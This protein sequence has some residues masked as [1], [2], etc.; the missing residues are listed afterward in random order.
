MS[1]HKGF[2]GAGGSSGTNARP[3]G[4]SGGG[5][6]Q[7]AWF[8]DLLAE[9]LEFGHVFPTDKKATRL[10]SAWI[11]AHRDKAI[12]VAH[13]CRR[14][15]LKL[16]KLAHDIDSQLQVSSTDADD[17][18]HGGGG[19][20]KENLDPTSATRNKQKRFM[21]AVKRHR[22]RESQAQAPQ[23]AEREPQP[24]QQQQDEI[25]SKQNGKKAEEDKSMI[26]RSKR[27]LIQSSDDSF[28][29]DEQVAARV[30]VSRQR[31]LKRQRTQLV[32]GQQQQRPLFGAG[33]PAPAPVPIMMQALPEAF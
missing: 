1:D 31:A 19:G 4:G 15:C 29:D 20:D 8:A 28:S 30:S 33:A 12:R 6:G 32:V 22:H 10:K 2:G 5:G 16:S 21:L 11:L 14:I 18:D 25:L 3:T 23:L 26:K 27:A 17:D 7:H 9:F 13:M 24:Q